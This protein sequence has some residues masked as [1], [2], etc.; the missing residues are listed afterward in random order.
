MS[1]P[2]RYDFSLQQ[3]C[4]RGATLTRGFARVDAYGDAVSIVGFT[5][6]MQVRSEAGEDA[7]LILDCASYL[8]VVSAAGGTMQLEIPNTITAGLTPGRYWYD[9]IIKS[10]SATIA[11]LQGNFD[12][13]LRTTVPP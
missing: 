13:S 8:S 3:A 11:L 4:Y 6:Y 12:V 9:L 2:A 7:T 1:A 10:A 5:P